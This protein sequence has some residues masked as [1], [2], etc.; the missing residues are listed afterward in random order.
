MKNKNVLILGGA[1]FIGSHLS[2]YLLNNGYKVISIGRGC[3]NIINKNYEHFSCD[4]TYN[5][6]MLNVNVANI[7]AVINCSGGGS[8]ANAQCEPFLDFEKTVLTTACIL[9]FIRK[10]YKKAK[11]IQLSSAAVY[12]EVEKLPIVVNETKCDPI[13]AYGYNNLS[14]EKIVEMYSRVYGINC[15]V[16]RIFSVYGDGLKKQILWD[17]LNKFSNGN[18]EAIFFGSGEEVRDFIHINDLILTIENV[19]KYT[20]TPVSIFNC[21]S[22]LGVKIKDVIGMLGVYSNIEC[23]VKFSGEKKPGDPIGYIASIMGAPIICNVSLDEGVRKYIDWFRNDDK[24]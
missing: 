13:S 2:L 23:K 1:G 24:K 16:L 3:S 8:V 9:D 4:I 6:L 12:G 17:A 22:G 18:D 11:F 19:F 10:K 21:A 14:A 20:T 15:C 5:N 7:F